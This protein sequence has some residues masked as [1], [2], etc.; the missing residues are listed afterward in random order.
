MLYIHAFSRKPQGL[1]SKWRSV[2]SVL[3]GWGEPHGGAKKGSRGTADRPYRGIRFEA[4][5]VGSGGE[6]VRE[7]SFDE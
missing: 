2:L 4:N 6:Q 5:E 3:P 7:M 1:M